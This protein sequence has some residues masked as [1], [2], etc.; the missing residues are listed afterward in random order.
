MKK[1]NEGITLIALVVTI[2]VLL[3]LAGISIESVLGQDGLIEKTN[4]A[5]D[6]SKQGEIKDKIKTM[7]AEW[8]IEKYTTGG[9]FE[10][11]LNEKKNTN[12]LDE[13]TKNLDGTFDVEK[14]G[15]VLTI[16]ENGTIL[17]TAKA[18]P[19]PQ[20]A[21]V[22]IGI[23]NSDGT[24]NEVENNQK[25][26]GT[27]LHITF[28]H[29]I[30]GGTTT[31]SPEIPYKITKNG[32][33]TFKIT[34]I[35]NT[36]S[37]EKTVNI[38]V[39]KF[40]TIVKVGDYVDY[41]V[42]YNNVANESKYMPNDKYSGKW[43]ILSIEENN[44]KI[45]SAGI[46]LTYC[47]G[48]WSTTSATNLTTNFFITQISNSGNTYRNCG[49]SG[50]ENTNQMKSLF[51]NDYTLQDESGKPQVRA[52]TKADVDKVY[53]SQT[54]SGTGVKNFDI[55]SIRTNN[56]EVKYTY[57]WLGEADLEQG[58]SGALYMIDAVPMVN[59]T[60]GGLEYVFGVRPVV[61]LVSNI[62]LNYKG[63]N[64]DGITEWSLSLKE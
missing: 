5:K 21:N 15:Y 22:K 63:L 33:Y 43:R 31:V 10:T 42:L 51:Q 29:S 3:I 30:E 27:E 4:E 47:N 17:E 60:Y 57:Y 64:D 2:V 24:I 58:H 12:E 18:G 55:L 62:E 54:K 50:V 13:V 28:E 34:G 8:Q 14:E 9:E 20:I 41:P 1:S 37:Y 53:G 38:K 46:P 11:F 23:K 49:F 48:T 19:R 16:K 6:T 59:S 39:E 35:V 52:M 32:I 56:D 7:L 40:K 44:M 61:T 36:I 26:E 25:D 45:V